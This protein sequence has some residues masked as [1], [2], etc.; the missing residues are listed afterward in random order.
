[1]WCHKGHFFL[2]W[3]EHG[4]VVVPRESVY[5]GEH[6]MPDSGVYYLVYLQ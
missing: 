3:L 4:D 1:M 5:E 2:I 6:S